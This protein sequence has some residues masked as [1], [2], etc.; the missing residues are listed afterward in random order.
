[1][2]LERVLS[3]ATAHT[4]AGRDGASRR[5][6][7]IVLAT[8]AAAGAFGLVLFAAP[9]DAQTATP[10]ET[11]VAQTDI[12]AGAIRPFRVNVPEAALVDLRQR[13]LA[14]RWPDKETV[15]DQS[16]GVPLATMRELA[17]YWATDYDWRKGEAKLGSSGFSVGDPQRWG[18]LR[19]FRG[20]TAAWHSWWAA[21]PRP[22]LERPPKP[23]GRG[24]V[25]RKRPRTP[26]VWWTGGTPSCRGYPRKTWKN[27]KK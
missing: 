9:C 20:R 23:R 3:T 18:S 6:R 7:R 21:W 1:M 12:T 4:T 10:R 25:H 27:Q 5:A 19:V 14:T 13:V 22:P 26:G 11:T 8:W 17:R 16:Q 2:T 24:V 15:A